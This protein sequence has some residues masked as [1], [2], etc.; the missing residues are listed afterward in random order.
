MSYEIDIVE[1]K[2]RISKG[3]EINLF[4]VREE[5]EY[6]ENNIGGTLIPLTSIPGRLSELISLKDE[7]VIVFCRTGSRSNQARMYL[8]SQG[9]S[10]VRSLLGGIEA[11]LGIA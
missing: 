6:E 4:D 3:E 11:Y 10:N 1:L 8:E 9:F 5:W 2:T 7:E